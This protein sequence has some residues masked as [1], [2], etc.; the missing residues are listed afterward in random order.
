[1][2]YNIYAGVNSLEYQYTAEFKTYNDAID[3]AYELALK[4]YSLVEGHAGYPTIE[5][6]EYSYCKDYGL[7]PNDLT[8]NDLNEINYI[9]LDEAESRISYDAIPQDEDPNII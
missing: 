1:M 2:Y 3:A 8:S 6:I 5:D 7:D 4:E 9:Y